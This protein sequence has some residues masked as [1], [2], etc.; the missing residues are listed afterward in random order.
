MLCTFLVLLVYLASLDSL[1]ATT[2]THKKEDIS[3]TQRVSTSFRD[4]S[5]WLKGICY[6]GNSPSISRKRG[7]HMC[8]VGMQSPVPCIEQSVPVKDPIPLHQRLAKH[9]SLVEG[10]LENGLTYV[11]L[12]NA[13]P[14]GRFEAHLEILSG[15]A[16]ELH[17]LLSAHARLV[18][19]TSYDALLDVMYCTTR[20][21]TV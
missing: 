6:S 16:K 13:V 2:S 20:T 10:K 11:I 3:P 19:E 18:L 21:I 7:I 9:E 14:A 5:Q 12:P 1:K 8:S 17:Q 4:S 15:S